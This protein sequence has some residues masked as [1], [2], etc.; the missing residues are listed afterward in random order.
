MS[1]VHQQRAF[2]LFEQRRYDHAARE[3]RQ[4]AADDPGDA[5]VRALLALCL[6]EQEQFGDAMREADE[7]VRLDPEMPFAHYARA[8]VLADRD[9]LSDASRAV[10]EAIRLDPE[11][12]DFHALR[13]RV[14]YAQERWASALAAAEAGLALD[15]EHTGSTNLRGLALRQLGRADEAHATLDGALERDPENAFA[16]ASRGWLM[17]ER[18]DHAKAM[19]HFAEALRLEPGLGFAREGLVTALKARYA[20]Y[21]VMLRY[22]LWMSKLDRRTRMFVVL[23]GVFASRLLRSLAKDTPAL[24]PIVWPLLGAYFLFVLLSW[25][26]DPLFNLLLRFNRYGRRALTRDE[27]V[28]SNWVGLAIAGA[29][30][31]GLAALAFRSSA[32]AVGAAGCLLL[33]LPLGGVFHTRRG[34]PRRVMAVYTA[35]AAAAGALGLALW[36]AA[37]ASADVPA[38]ALTLLVIFFGGAVLSGWVANGLALARR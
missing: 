9:K 6:S 37:P 35:V 21:G 2:V 23:G 19:E 27:T 32:F 36:L 28:A 1:G 38:G 33:L 4:A 22:F 16:H 24:R 15:A 14:L 8:S 10:D 29:A 34:W 12:A 31:L 26:A 13:A 11:H 3:L 7:A 25:T 20:V 17:L 30:T 5:F 18:R